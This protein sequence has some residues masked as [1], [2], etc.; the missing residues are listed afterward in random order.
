M[1]TEEIKFGE[2]DTLSAIAAAAVGAE[3][4]INLSD[5]D[6]LYTSD[7]KTDP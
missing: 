1:A 6:G 2:N 4:L 7:P 3:L 5:V